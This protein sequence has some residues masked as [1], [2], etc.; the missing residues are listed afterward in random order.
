MA[1]SLRWRRT[2][3]ATDEIL[4]VCLPPTAYAPGGA[5]EIW[6]FGSMLIAVLVLIVYAIANVKCRFMGKSSEVDWK[7]GFFSAIAA[8]EISLNRVKRLLS[9]LNL[10]M[11]IYFCTWFLTVTMLVL[12]QVSQMGILSS[13]KPPTPKSQRSSPTKLSHLLNSPVQF[14]RKRCNSMWTSHSRL[15]KWPRRRCK[16]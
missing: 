11:G 14:P 9:S 2:F 5:R 16:W 13:F 8:T 12:T 10:V 15:F 7:R 6:I 3:P 1:S 4:A